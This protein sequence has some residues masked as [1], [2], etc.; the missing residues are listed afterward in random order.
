[1]ASRV[2]LK[3]DGNR[4]RVL[5]RGGTIRRYLRG[6]PQAKL[7]LGSGPHLKAGWLNADKFEPRADIY[8][9]T[10]ARFPFKDSS[11]CSV[12]SEHML[13]HVRI[14]KVRFLLEEVRRVLKPGG[15]FRVTVPDLELFARKYVE[16]DDTFF[17]PYLA[18]HRENLR[19]GKAKHWIVRTHGSAFMSM[20]NV[21]F[22]RHRW[23]Y[24]FE[25]LRALSE[26]VGFSKAIK[27][28]FR[29]G[30]DGEVAL[31][32]DECRRHETLYVDLLK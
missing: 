28:S 10:Y 14:D 29:E 18:S 23:M 11:F 15:L 3:G 32:D 24:D 25:T 22:H 12:Y 4:L 8:L 7:H 9:N 26:E 17:K 16:G 31:L 1:M 27:Q 19:N 21:L 2:F 20:C 6:H 13:E 30:V 5:T